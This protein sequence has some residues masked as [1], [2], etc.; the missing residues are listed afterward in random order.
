MK[1]SAGII[2]IWNKNILLAHPTNHKMFSTWDIPK[3]AVEDG[4]SFKEAA[5]RETRE[6]VGLCIDPDEVEDEPIIIDYIDK[7][8]QLF[9]KVYAFKYYCQSLKEIGL[10]YPMIPVEHLQTIEMDMAAFFPLNI[11]EDYIF[12][13]YKSILNQI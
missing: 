8:G 2:I 10:E 6:E 11:A 4:E 5:L 9:K 3:G 12:W 13:R 7:E 1:I